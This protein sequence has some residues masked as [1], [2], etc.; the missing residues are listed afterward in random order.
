MPTSPPPPVP[1][2]PLSARACSGRRRRNASRDS[3]PL[4]GCSLRRPLS[5]GRQPLVPHT[6]FVLRGGGGGHC[7]RMVKV[8]RSAFPR[9]R[10]HP[11][12]HLTSAP[13]SLTQPEPQ[14]P[15][16]RSL[17]GLAKTRREFAAVLATA[18]DDDAGDAPR[19]SPLLFARGT[20]PFVALGTIAAGAGAMTANPLA[21]PPSRR[22]VRGSSQVR[23]G[24]IAGDRSA[25]L[26]YSLCPPGRACRCCGRCIYIAALFAVFAAPLVIPFQVR[27]V[28]L[29]LPDPTPHMRRFCWFQ[30]TL[31]LICVAYF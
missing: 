30:A 24:T 11:F 25:A 19:A 16:A 21:R 26:T 10:R 18:T 29:N 15:G 2:S 31:A 23:A 13:V 22:S 27:Q 28:A 6:R 7:M 14:L 17:A 3:R 20:K 9:G 4:W 8:K 5:S 12:S 1:P